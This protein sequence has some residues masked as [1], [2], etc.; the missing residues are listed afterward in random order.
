VTEREA[1]ARALLP[2]SRRRFLALAGAAA[3]TGL[4][5]SGCSPT[6]PAWLRPPSGQVLRHLDARSYATLA[7]ATARLVG[8]PGAS[9]IAEGRLAPAAV[10]DTWLGATPGVAPRLVQGLLLLELGTWPLLR[11][12]R[13]FTA[14]PPERQDAVLAD[15]EAARLD[16]KRELFRG[17][18]S[19]AFLTFY[20]DPGVR[21]RI[22]HP[23]PFGRGRVSI[24][25]AMSYEGLR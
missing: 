19:I 18:R 20:S 10:A 7:T 22:G 8:E 21:A 11:K 24:A 12:I 25:D 16:L 14:L 9:W 5:G 3:A 1:L 15:L 17:L 4:L 2:L 13:P 23:G 6:R